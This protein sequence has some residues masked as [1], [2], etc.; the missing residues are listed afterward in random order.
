MTGEQK[1][2]WQRASSDLLAIVV[3]AELARQMGDTVDKPQAVEALAARHE[4]ADRMRRH[5]W[6][7]IEAARSAG[8]S[9]AEIDTVLGAKAGTARRRYEVT[10]AR[11]KALGLAEPDRHDPGTPE[12]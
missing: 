11:Q 12:R 3:D 7:A 1:P 2:L 4:L 8:A 6:L 5:G 9:W 10:L